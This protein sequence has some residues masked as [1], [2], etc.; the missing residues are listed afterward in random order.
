MVKFHFLQHLNAFASVRL[1]FKYPTFVL[2]ASLFILSLKG[3]IIVFKFKFYIFTTTSTHFKVAIS[4]F[5]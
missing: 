2:S 4:S 5:Y 3:E 1:C